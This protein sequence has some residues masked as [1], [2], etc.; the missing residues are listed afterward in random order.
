MTSQS[1]FVACSSCKAMVHADAQRCSACGVPR[2][3]RH[4]GR[5]IGGVLLGLVVL[6]LL[7]SALTVPNTPAAPSEV[8]ELVTLDY[9]WRTTA[10]GAIME[11]D[12]VVDNRAG[13][14]VKDVRIECTHYSPSG[15]RI[16]SNSE[17]LYEVFP[18]HGKVSKRRV[19]MGFIHSQADRTQCVIAKYSLVA[20]T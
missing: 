7:Q 3:H 17:T 1:L 11:A 10:G 14:P 8:S 12:F 20:P 4:L 19:N 15:T 18:A 6:S 5:W 16:D 13:H 9:E 2:R